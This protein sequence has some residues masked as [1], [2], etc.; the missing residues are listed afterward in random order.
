M[1]SF[2]E[3]AITAAVIEKAFLNEIA[4]EDKR[5]ELEK[6]IADSI[7]ARDAKIA[8]KEAARVAEEA[9]YEALFQSAITETIE[10]VKPLIPPALHRY[11]K[12]NGAQPT[13]RYVLDAR[14][15]APPCLGINAPGLAPL[16]I[17]IGEDDDEQS[18]I[19]R[20]EVDDST[21][22]F[23]GN[24]WAEAIAAAVDRYH[25]RRAEYSRAAQALG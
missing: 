12:F 4:E 20:I 15:W 24:E 14:N 1:N 10:R 16:T 25:E 6:L 18:C 8:E 7:A 3:E 21:C 13:N 19:W 23:S 9:R 2:S 17:T 22:G 5:T 11:I